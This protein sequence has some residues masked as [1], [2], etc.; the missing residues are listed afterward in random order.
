MHKTFEGIVD[1]S[2]QIRLLEPTPLPRAG[3]VL[4]T[5]LDSCG[6]AM[7]ESALLAE[8]ALA[9]YWNRPEEDE[10]WRDLQDEAM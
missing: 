2:G 4:V 3:R 9:E 6:D 7:A 8:P 10:A 1:E 5:L